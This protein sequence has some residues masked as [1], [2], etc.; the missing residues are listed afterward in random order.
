MEPCERVHSS[1]RSRATSARPHHRMGWRLHE[2]ESTPSSACTR[3][4]A[5]R[6]Y[7]SQQVVR[8]AVTRVRR[9]HRVC[10]VLGGTT[11][12]LEVNTVRFIDNFSAGAS[13][14][15]VQ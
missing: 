14:V 8:C 7:S 2:P 4:L 11:V 15:H 10:M 3:L 12:P 5:G 6:S 1:K 13:L 9:Q